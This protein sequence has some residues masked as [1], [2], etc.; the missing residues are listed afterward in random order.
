[1]EIATYVGKTSYVKKDVYKDG[2]QSVDYT[3][4]GRKGQIITGTITKVAKQIS[5]DFSGTQVSVA[6]TAVQDAKEGQERQFEIKDVTKDRI[7]LKEVETTDSARKQKGL[8]QTRIAG[9][10]PKIQELDTNP[11]EKTEEDTDS[12][13]IAKKQSAAD[14][15]HADILKRVTEEDC[16]ALEA[17]GISLEKYAYDR[18][19]TALARIKEQRQQRQTGIEATADSMQEQEEQIQKIALSSA[20]KTGVGKV[21]QG[22]IAQYLRMADLPVTPEL[23]AAATQALQMA[24]VVPDLSESA[25]AYMITEEMEPSISN[26]YRAQYMGSSQRFQQYNPQNF[27]GYQSNLVSYAQVETVVD[28]KQLDASWQSILPQVEQQLLQEGMPVTPAYLEDAKWLFMHQIPIVADNLEQLQELQ[29][30]RQEYTETEALNQI[31][32]TMAEGKTAEQT[33]LRAVDF[34]DSQKSIQAFLGEVE[35]ALVELESPKV[36]KEAKTYLT[37]DPLQKKM[38][39]EKA[40]LWMTVEAGNRLQKKGI[41]LAVSNV[42]EI[43]AELE[44]E[45]EKGKQALFTEAGFQEQEWEQTV[46]QETLSKTAQI[47][48]MPATALGVTFAERKEITLDALYQTGSRIQEQMQANAEVTEAFDTIGKQWMQA[49]AHLSYEKNE[50]QVDK[51]LGDSLQ[52]AFTNI[53]SLLK[54]LDLE[55]SRANVRAVKILAHNHMDISKENVMEMK[56]YDQ[57]V[58]RILDT[59][60]P[61]VTMELI[62]EKMNPLQM[63]LEELQTQI[64]NLRD[65]LGLDGTEKYSKYLLQL[66]RSNGI[67]SEDRQTYINV[68]RLLHNVQKLDGAAVGYVLHSNREMNLENLL[69]ASKTLTGHGVET[70][71]TDSQDAR[72]QVYSR[73]TLLSQLREGFSDTKENQTETK[74]YQSVVDQVLEEISPSKLQVVATDGGKH[75]QQDSGLLQKNLEQLLE[76]MQQVEVESEENVAEIQWKEE[77]RVKN[78]R[79]IADNSHVLQEALD[80]RGLDG[81]LGQMVAFAQKAN[82]WKRLWDR[83]K[84]ASVEKQ[85]GLKKVFTNLVDAL[86]RPEQLEEE[87]IKAMQEAETDLYADLQNRQ[88]RAEQLQEMQTCVNGVR[89]YQAL[90]K[91]EEYEIPL[92]I[93]EQVTHVHVAFVS[94]ADKESGAS[95]TMETPKLGKITA[96]LSAQEAGVEAKV[97]CTFVKAKDTLLAQAESLKAALEKQSL[98]LDTLEVQVTQQGKDW[99]EG[100]QQ[101]TTAQTNHQLYQMSKAFIQFIQQV[102]E[103]KM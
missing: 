22:R 7:V 3:S 96:N 36:E 58:N 92:L 41:T 27:A 45:I 2:K 17:E 83:R 39:L 75:L 87:Y 34:T 66:E 10:Q 42:E 38:Q 6:K 26:L 63:P 73:S 100:G 93:G 77:L 14:S 56:A 32:Q 74:Y 13:E 99:E 46:L 40:R 16:D 35:Q 64:E 19:E 21:N 24:N 15:E 60:H 23:L 51:S 98:A 72:E 53:P 94:D 33:I 50:T 81:T 67:S 5:I 71:V 95:V 44:Q 61:A 49:K 1:M 55:A 84:Q 29:D 18:L 20:I 102:E 57:Q 11:E 89:M 88:V 54:E 76:E 65:D 90:A 4:L 69:V 59:L 25:M 47:K 103:E 70:F 86:D 78:M 52:K 62:K 48:E 68:Y 82:H 85:E 43:V 97:T 9:Q 31:T 101:R 12:E 37:E 80:T 79:E 8:Q 91:R 28:P 30:L